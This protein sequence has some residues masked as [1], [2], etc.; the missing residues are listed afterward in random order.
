MH[1]SAQVYDEGMKG[2]PRLRFL[3]LGALCMA[4]VGCY[5]HVVGARGYG[6]AGAD[7]YEPNIREPGK[8][9]KTPIQRKPPK[10][11]SSHD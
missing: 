4:C 7:L 10:R 1:L 5:E 2:R 9:Q 6:A 8:D 3:V 11:M